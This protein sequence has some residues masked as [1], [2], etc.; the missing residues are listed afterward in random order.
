MRG[1]KLFLLFLIFCSL[2]G[3]S[4][5]KESVKGFAGVSTKV[6]EDNRKE[7]KVKDFGFS[8]DITRSKVKAALKEEGSYIYSEG[9]SSNLIAVYVSDKDTTPVGIF[10]TPLDENNTRIEVSSPSTYGKEVI[11][12]A[13]F[14]SLSGI[15]KP[16]VEK[17]IFD[18]KR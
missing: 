13:I 4:V 16:K 10:L 17:G 2:N 15:V 8:L 11:A 18:V 1:L 7:A 12:D 5:V 6:L 3:C 14:N 9:L